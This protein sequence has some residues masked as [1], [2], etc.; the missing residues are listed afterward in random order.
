MNSSREEFST[1][2]FGELCVSGQ[3]AENIAQ[4]WHVRFHGRIFDFR[5]AS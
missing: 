3:A 4:R 1:V 2:L 5:G